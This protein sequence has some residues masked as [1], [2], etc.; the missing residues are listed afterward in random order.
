MIQTMMLKCTSFF[1]LFLY[2]KNIPL[3]V[4]AEIT[5]FCSIYTREQRIYTLCRELKMSGGHAAEMR[6]NGDE[7]LI[8]LEGVPLQSV[9][10]I[11]SRRHLHGHAVR[12]LVDCLNCV[13]PA[14]PDAH[15]QALAPLVQ[16]PVPILLMEIQ[17]I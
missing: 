6:E 13:L 14:S 5:V 7:I 2:S 1:Q 4:V 9:H 10:L 16:N 12:R 8:N 17:T 3:N 15:R 11:H